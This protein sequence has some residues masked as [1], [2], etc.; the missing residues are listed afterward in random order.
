MPELQ[1][2]TRVSFSKPATSLNYVTARA[3]EAGSMQTMQSCSSSWVCWRFPGRQPR[4]EA[5][6]NGTLPVEQ[7]G[8]W[9]GGCL[10]QRRVD[11]E[12]LA[13]FGNVPSPRYCWGA[14]GTAQNRC[15]E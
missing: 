10:L 14:A 5:S 11:Q 12:T 6:L 15:V 8:D 4:V 1:L 13:I 9:R 2:P 7:H 3:F